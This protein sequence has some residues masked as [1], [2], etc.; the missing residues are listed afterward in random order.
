MYTLPF[1]D[2]GT[3]VSRDTI[4]GDPVSSP[5]SDFGEMKAIVPQ[6]GNLFVKTR[7]QL[8]ATAKSRRSEWYVKI[9]ERAVRSG[10]TVL[11]D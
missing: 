3:L 9:D 4:Q 6:T 8:V 7:S 1:H 10:R 2:S 11:I 5:G